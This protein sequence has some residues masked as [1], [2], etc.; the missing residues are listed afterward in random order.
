[1]TIVKPF[2]F[3]FII[4][5]CIFIY[6]FKL[7][8]CTEVAKPLQRYLFLGVHVHI[9]PRQSLDQKRAR[10]CMPVCVYPCGWGR[11]V[12]VLRTFVRA[13]N[14]TLQHVEAMNGGK[15]QLC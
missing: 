15:T 11:Y 7:L 3:L 2:E 6:L 5:R 13:C 12:G 8:I 4:N 1:M 9:L 14:F 10:V